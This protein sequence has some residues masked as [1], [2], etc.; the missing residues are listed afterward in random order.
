MFYITWMLI[1]G[2]KYFLSFCGFSFHFLDGILWDTNGFKTS[3]S[4]SLLLLM[5]L[6]SHLKILSQIQSNGNLTLCF[7]LMTQPDAGECSSDLCSS[8][9]LYIASCFL[10]FSFTNSNCLKQKNKSGCCYSTMTE[11]RNI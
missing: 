3:I 2:G 5:Y 7:L 11:N 4:V 6:A 8:S 10:A 1:P 9:S